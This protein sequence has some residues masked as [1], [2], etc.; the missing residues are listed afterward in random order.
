MYLT[1]YSEVRLE[2]CPNSRWHPLFED[3][4]QSPPSV[5]GSGW[6]TNGRQLGWQPNQSGWKQ[7]R[8]SYLCGHSY[9]ILVQK[10]TYTKSVIAESDMLTQ[11]DGF[12]PAS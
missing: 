2:R 8:C 1:D 6:A 12:S 4:S 10:C 7:G 5:M 3:L 11:S 9:A